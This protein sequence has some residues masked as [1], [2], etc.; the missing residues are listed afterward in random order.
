MMVR[1]VVKNCISEL[2]IH[3]VLASFFC[4]RNKL[5]MTVTSSSI[6]GKEGDARPRDFGGFSPAVQRVHFT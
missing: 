6:E 1:N 3:E 4:I 2:K 5:R